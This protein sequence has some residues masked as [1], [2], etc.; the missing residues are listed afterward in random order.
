MHALFLDGFDERESQQ[1]LDVA[2]RQRQQHRRT[3]RTAHFP[4][5][6]RAHELQGRGTRLRMPL[7]PSERTR[8]RHGCAEDV[9]SCRG[10]RRLVVE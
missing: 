7:L 5:V 6:F 3:G 10:H 8:V 1:L 2:T 9:R 4:H